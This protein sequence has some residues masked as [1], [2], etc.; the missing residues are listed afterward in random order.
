MEKEVDLTRE[1]QGLKKKKAKHFS[2]LKNL[3]KLTVWWTIFPG[4]EAMCLFSTLRFGF[5]IPKA[6]SL[7]AQGQ[8]PG[9]LPKGGAKVAL[10]E[11]VVAFL[12]LAGDLIDSPVLPDSFGSLG[13]CE[14]IPMSS[15]TIIALLPPTFLTTLTPQE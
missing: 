14:A 8:K 5:R 13:N 2:F 9:H 15:V 12:G 6:F 10:K 1:T 4:M 7:G 11:S 3:V